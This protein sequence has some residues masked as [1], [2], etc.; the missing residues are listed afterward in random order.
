MLNQAGISILQGRSD[1]PSLSTHV[2]TRER[3]SI[4]IHSRTNQHP[5]Q[6]PTHLHN[7]LYNTPSL[8][9]N[10]HSPQ[11]EKQN[12]PPR[13]KN[14]GNPTT[15]LQPSSPSHDRVRGMRCGAR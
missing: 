11:N 9:P 8:P 15:P 13:P 14:N 5:K 1:R 4:T 10:R 3:S 12:I 6:P 2:P 7:H